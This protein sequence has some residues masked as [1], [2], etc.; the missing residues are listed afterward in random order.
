MGQFNVYVFLTHCYIPNPIQVGSNIFIQPFQGIGAID[1]VELMD[2]YIEEVLHNKKHPQKMKRA[3]SNKIQSGDHS[4]VLE[5]NN[6]IAENYVE[7]IKSTEASVM[8]C[9]D[10]LAFRQLQRGTI[11]SF[12]SVQTDVNPY[13][14]TPHVRR[15]YHSL[16]KVRNLPIGETESKIFTCYLTK[17][18]QYPTLEA[19][20]SLYAD[21]TTY[22]DTL[23]SDLG[24]ETRLIK[25][26]GLLETMAYKEKGNKKQKVKNLFKRYQLT[27]YPNF[28][29]HSDK[30][31][32]DIAYNWRKIIAHSGSCT[33]T[34]NDRDKEFCDNY[35]PDFPKVLEKLNQ[36]CRFLINAFANSL[37]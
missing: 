29:A 26:W 28:L 3:I 32:L 4:I 23:S 18:H 33:S 12:L 31:L 10:I 8:L 9:R 11:A 37:P 6:I 30:D 24:Y 22:N 13:R 21:S 15:Q 1:V 2:R 14:F 7:A 25:I 20:L 36:S 34:T 27:T 5:V 19:Y 16:R 35:S 17:A